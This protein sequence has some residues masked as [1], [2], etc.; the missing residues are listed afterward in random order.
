[1]QTEFGAEIGDQIAFLQAAGQRLRRGD[2]RVIGVIGGEHAIHGFEKHRIGGGMVERL[3][4]GA[5]E[6]GL[7]TVI[8]GAP[9]TGAKPRKQLAGGTLPAIPKIAGQGFEPRQARRND[10]IDFDGETGAGHDGCVEEWL[11][12]F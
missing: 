12:G 1:M 5:F 2:R 9:Q 3:L 10:G 8:G 11:S 6:H 7:R 4:V